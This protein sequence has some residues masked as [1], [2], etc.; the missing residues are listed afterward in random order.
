MVGD[1]SEL[2]VQEEETTAVTASTEEVAAAEPDKASPISQTVVTSAVVGK[3]SEFVVQKKEPASTE[4]V[5]P[6]KVAEA[7]PISEP[8]VASIVS[9]KPSAHESE[10]L[11]QFSSDDGSVSGDREN[12]TG[13]TL[14]G[15]RSNTQK[16]SP[17][18]GSDDVPPS[19]PT[20][21]S[22]STEPR[23]HSAATQQIGGS[24]KRYQQ[25]VTYVASSKSEAGHGS[26]PV[27]DD[28]E[29]IAISEAAVEYVLQEEI[30]AKRVPEKM[31]FTNPGFDVK[32]CDPVT[33]EVRFIEVKGT[34][35]AWDKM[36][37]QLTP[38][39]F[40]FSRTKGSEFWLY[41]VE[42]ARGE[43]PLLYCFQDPFS[44]VDQYRFDGGWKGLADAAMP[45]RSVQIPHFA[46][47]VKVS[48]RDSV[49][50]EV[51]GIVEEIESSGEL[52]RLTIRLSDGTK[53]KKFLDSTLAVVND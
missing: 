24:T 42:D 9:D 53:V 13:K 49:L 26:P 48:L 36:G 18:Y 20:L 12:L 5:A 11:E 44:Q 1:N 6:A 39:Q 27:E 41:V 2:G 43:K 34:D 31:H 51:R 8:G 50:G 45:D 33:G 52:Q 38:T 7:S 46:V 35:G 37:V 15:A 10:G 40:E 19:T 22:P 28:P 3:E 16:V 25:I 32:S 21:I 23:R 17:G 47:G 30:W 4:G 14:S 29:N